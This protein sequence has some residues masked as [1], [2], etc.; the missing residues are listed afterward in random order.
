VE[1]KFEE[2]RELIFRQWFLDDSNLLIRIEK[3]V[4]EV[5]KKQGLQK[6]PFKRKKI[7]ILFPRAGN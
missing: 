2:S 6:R 7:S 1:E 4:K 5:A 3:I